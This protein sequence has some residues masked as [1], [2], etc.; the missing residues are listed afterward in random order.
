LS[1]T[2]R[3][4]AHRC[5]AAL[6]WAS[7]LVGAA[8]CE[9][10]HRDV[11][12]VQATHLQPLEMAG[13]TVAGADDTTV[14]WLGRGM[15][16]S[17]SPNGSFILNEDTGM[18]YTIDHAARSY[19][20]IPLNDLGD[21]PKLL[22]IDRAD[23]DSPDRRLQLMRNFA[24]LEAEVRPTEQ[25]AE[26][27]GYRCRRYEMKLLM[28]RAHIATTYW[29]T[30]DTDVDTDLLRRITSAALLNLPGADQMIAEMEKMD[31]LTVLT[32]GTLEFL[33]Q[34]SHTSS[35]LLEIAYGDA[36]PG[37]FTVP[38]AYLRQNFSLPVD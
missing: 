24:S 33:G 18:F 6:L 14:V 35:R 21:L 4:A 10:G 36:P 13:Q 38:E 22:G 29:V 28:G 26:I 1:A 31:G 11:R 19:V 37:T 2:V 5:G 30:R 3:V 27:A 32:E 15:A 7:L 8:A 16:R 25:F 9:R 23:E 12:L 20:A 34:T 17:D